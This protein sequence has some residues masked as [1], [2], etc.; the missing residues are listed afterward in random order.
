MANFSELADRIRRAGFDDVRWERWSGGI[1]ALHTAV[2]ADQ[3][4][5]TASRS[6]T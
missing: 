1:V 2:R 3:A 4:T 5:A 6:P